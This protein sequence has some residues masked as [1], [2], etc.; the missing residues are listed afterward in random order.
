MAVRTKRARML[1]KL[2]YLLGP[3]IESY[4]REEQEEPYTFSTAVKQT[5]AIYGYRFW[6]ERGN[7]FVEAK[8]QLL[9]DYADFME[10]IS[11]VNLSE[12]I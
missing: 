1:Y 5:L 4:Q 12:K 6:A 10:L 11:D 9:K 8:A 2:I 7:G 3:E